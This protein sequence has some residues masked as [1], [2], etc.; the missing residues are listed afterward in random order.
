M[1]KEKKTFEEGFFIFGLKG[2]YLDASSID[3]VMRHWTLVIRIAAVRHNLAELRS[4]RWGNDNL[5]PLFSA[6]YSSFNTSYPRR[7]QCCYR[8]FLFQFQPWK[9]LRRSICVLF[10]FWKILGKSKR[11]GATF[12]NHFNLTTPTSCL[13]FL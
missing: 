7:K 1:S 12:Y 10:N 5:F 4:F 2:G 6:H 3:W 11:G 9:Y 8:R 13:V